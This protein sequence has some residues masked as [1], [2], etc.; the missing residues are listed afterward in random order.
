MTTCRVL[1]LMCTVAVMLLPCDALPETLVLQ[2]GAEGKDTYICDCS[3]D[4][5]NPNGP[6]SHLYQGQYVSCYD[7]LL[8][9]WD[10]SSLPEENITIDSAIMELKFNALHGSE[11]G[12][13]VYFPILED[14][15]ETE[16]T[17]NTQPAISREDSV[18]TRWPN[19]GEW[20]QIDLTG[21]VTMWHDD[22]ASNHGTYGHCFET[23]STCC[24]EFQSSDCSNEE[25]HPK[26][27]IVYSVQIG[28][29]PT[30][31]GLP[32]Q[33]SAVDAYPN[34]F[35]SLLNIRYST[36]SPGPVT[37]SICDLLGRQ[38]ATVD[39]AVVPAGENVLQ[40]SPAG[41]PSGTYLV[42]VKDANG[43]AIERVMLER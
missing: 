26:L 5:N 6:I 2:P 24:A 37:L 42:I 28:T 27:T 15:V 8:I 43:T 9:E 25:D 38:V 16:V 39:N 18:V 4:V 31:G 35:T 11:S 3:P 32:A 41:T 21:F 7:R 30:E 23:T 17:Y 40:W 36:Q 10:L 29:N 14:W 34:P 20:H 1:L 13:M 33:I 19:P 22:P 12:Q